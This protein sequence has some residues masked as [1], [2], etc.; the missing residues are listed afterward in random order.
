MSVK[1]RCGSCG[2]ER[3]VPQEYVGRKIRCPQCQ[4]KERF[5]G[6]DETLILE[7]GQL[8][9]DGR[10]Q[11]AAP[12]APLPPARGFTRV[13]PASQ[14]DP[15]EFDDQLLF[16]PDELDRRRAAEKAAL[17]QRQRRWVVGLLLAALGLLG[18][19]GYLIH[20]ALSL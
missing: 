13:D 16:E 4:T 15:A 1:Y 14:F 7:P 19:G 11:T 6:A 5:M 8:P 12:K 3:E 10:A 9:S 17:A 18:I 20:L 2:Y